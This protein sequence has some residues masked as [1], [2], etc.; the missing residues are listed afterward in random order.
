MM[1]QDKA[2]ELYD[3]GHEASP[4]M[5]CESGGDGKTRILMVCPNLK[6]G[7]RLY[8]ALVHF[9]AP[10]VPTVSTYVVR[11][12]LPGEHVFHEAVTM[13]KSAT[14]AVVGFRKRYGGVAYIEECFPMEEWDEVAYGPREPAMLR[15]ERFDCASGEV[16]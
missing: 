9:F 1:D 12:H 2:T 16:I 7:Q 15:M 13:A 5:T 6:T 10:A 8:S 11:W 14:E 3:A 4:F